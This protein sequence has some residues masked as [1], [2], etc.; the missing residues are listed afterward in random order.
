MLNQEDKFIHKIKKDGP[1]IEPVTLPGEGIG[2]YG[3]AVDPSSNVCYAR[4]I[5]DPETGKSVF[6]IRR[7]NSGHDAGHFL[8]PRSP[9]YNEGDE[10][11]IQARKGKRLFE[12]VRVTQE[13]YDYYIKFL[14]TGNIAWLRA[15]ER[16]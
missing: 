10:R 8:N 15:A 3:N 14:Q 4:K 6:L 16:A 11:R 9:F 1:G 2:E 7:A 5:A 13:Q 12:F